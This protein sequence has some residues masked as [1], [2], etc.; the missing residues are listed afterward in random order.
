MAERRSHPSVG[1]PRRAHPASGSLAHAGSEPE[2]ILGDGYQ[3]KGMARLAQGRKAGRIAL[4][5]AAEC[6]AQTVE[7]D[8]DPAQVPTS[9]M[10]EGA[11]EPE[12]QRLIA[13]R[14]QIQEKSVGQCRHGQ[15]LCS[16]L[17]APQT[18]TLE[19]QFAFIKTPGEFDLPSARISKDDAPGV[20]S[21]RDR[22][23]GQQIPGGA[24]PAA[25][26][27]LSCTQRA[28]RLSQTVRSDQ[29]R[30]PKAMRQ[31]LRRLPWASSSW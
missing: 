11:Q 13:R 15:E 29:P 2:G 21:S 31:A 25:P 9:T 30:L 28:C 14:Q 7:R 3:A 1:Q 22:L 4:P 27:R 6:R 5:Q 10:T 19:S 17:L 26:A 16:F 23:S 24:S 12:P 20:F 18:R 8:L